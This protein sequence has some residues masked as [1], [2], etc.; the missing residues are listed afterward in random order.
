[1]CT[2]PAQ[3]CRIGACQ[4]NNPY[5]VGHTDFTESF[6]PPADTLFVFPVS[7]ASTADVLSLGL[8]ARSNTGA[9]ARMVVYADNAGA[10]GALLARA[11]SDM[12]VVAGAVEQTP[13]PANTQVVGGKQYWI[14]VEFF[15]SAQVYRS[16]SASLPGGYRLAHTYAT[17]YPD[18]FV[19]GNAIPTSSLGM[20][21]YLV[22]RDVTP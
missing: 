3:I 17:A 7:V 1:M 6:D 15:G 20:N 21:L 12:T 11:G 13:T 16:S 5:D 22:V 10:P 18:P 8:T 19:P 9:Y 4:A 2:G 14:A